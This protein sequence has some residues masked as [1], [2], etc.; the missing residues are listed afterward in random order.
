M[1]TVLRVIL[2]AVIG[3]ALA[4]AS[5]C[6][7]PGGDLAADFQSED[8]HCRVAAIRQA[9]ETKDPQS[10][11]YLVDR[12]TDSEQEVR[13]FAILALERV[14]GTTMGYEY[15]GP[16]GERAEAVQRWRQ[17]LRDGRVASRQEAKDQQ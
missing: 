10:L 6:K 8:P 16:S 7:Q 1:D 2:L 13:F 12:L 4:Q 11:P 3:G 5:G 17:W 9:G 15:Y 14:T